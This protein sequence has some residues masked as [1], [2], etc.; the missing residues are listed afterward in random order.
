MKHAQTAAQM[1]VLYCTVPGAGRNNF[2]TSL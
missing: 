2:M 1:H